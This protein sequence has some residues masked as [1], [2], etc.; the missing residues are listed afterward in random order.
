MIR[1]M[2]IS[3]A[4]MTARAILRLAASGRPTHASV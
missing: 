3:I 1:S 4:R 2:S